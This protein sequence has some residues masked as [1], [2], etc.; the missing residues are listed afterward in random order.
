MRLFGLNLRIRSVQGRGASEITPVVL[1]AT[2]VVA[3]NLSDS[4]RSY[5]ETAN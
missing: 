3:A 5:F 1:A 2:A 4:P